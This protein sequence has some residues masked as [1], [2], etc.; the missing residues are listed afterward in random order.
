MELLRTPQVP[1]AGNAAAAGRPDL[2]ADTGAGHV[3]HLVLP[4]RALLLLVADLAVLLTCLPVL[5][6]LMMRQ[7]AQP[8]CQDHLASL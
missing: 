5:R 4:G 3:E 7:Q 2:A 6:G 8:G 1:P